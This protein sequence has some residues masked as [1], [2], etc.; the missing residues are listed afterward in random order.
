MNNL[1]TTDHTYLSIYFFFHYLCLF[2]CTTT[3]IHCSIIC[4]HR[5]F[6]IVFYAKFGKVS[7]LPFQLICKSFL[8]TRPS[9]IVQMYLC[10]GVYNDD[11][12]EIHWQLYILSH[13][14]YRKIRHFYWKYIHCKRFSANSFSLGFISTMVYA[15]PFS[16]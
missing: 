3:V 8:V 15:L 1:C 7:L 14:Q 5:K 13:Y 12:K 11:A 4:R 16:L 6:T 10:I 2:R 9:S